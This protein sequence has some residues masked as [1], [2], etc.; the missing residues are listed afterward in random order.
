MVAEA[1]LVVADSHLAADI[2]VVTEAVDVD[3]RHISVYYRAGS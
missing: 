2:V 1:G 3:I